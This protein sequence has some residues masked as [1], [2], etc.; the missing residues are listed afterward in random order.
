MGILDDEENYFA[1]RSGSGAFLGSD[2]DVSISPLFAGLDLNALGI[3]P[4]LFAEGLDLS[5]LLPDIIGDADVMAALKAQDPAAYAAL[6]TAGGGGNLQTDYAVTDKNELVDT[7]GNNLDA[8]IKSSAGADTSVNDAETKKL[9]RQADLTASGQNAVANLGPQGDT[10]VKSQSADTTGTK[11]LIDTAKD[12]IKDI[13]GLDAGDAAKYAAMLAIAKMAYDDA[14]RAREEARGWS[15]PGG[16]SKQAV[17]SPGGGVSFKKAAMGG[18]IGSLDMAR[19]GRTLPPRYLDGHSDGMADKVPANIDGKRPA[20]LSDGEFVI[21][22]DV[23]SHLGNG[24][25]NA[26]AK[27][28]YKM[29]DDIRAARTGNPKQGKQ[30]NPDKFMPR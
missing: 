11:S 22:A 9:Q 23:V 19:G 28:L 6:L 13:T 27:R 12:A 21:P 8:I 14:Q 20:A 5:A 10:G 24:N 16:Y 29:M 4:N 1:G 26:G 7:K 18:G 3:D 2:E 15:A 17:R 30:I 25:S